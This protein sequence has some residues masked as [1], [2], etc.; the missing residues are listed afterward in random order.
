MNLESLMLHERNQPF[1]VALWKASLENVQLISEAQW[2]EQCESQ[3][4]VWN[5]YGAEATSYQFI[6]LCML[7]SYSC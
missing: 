2:V 4:S 5:Q 7:L 6:S 3:K 1:L